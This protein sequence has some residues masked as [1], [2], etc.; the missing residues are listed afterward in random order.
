MQLHLEIQQT[1]LRKSNCH[2]SKNNTILKSSFKL[3]FRLLLEFGS[4]AAPL[5]ENKI[6]SPALF[7]HIPATKMLHFLCYSYLYIHTTFEG[8]P[9]SPSSDSPVCLRVFTQ[10]T[11]LLSLR[12]MC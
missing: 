12:G 11:M 7:R 2:N 3:I 8:P 4:V 6:T 5:K 1:W 9:A 10:L